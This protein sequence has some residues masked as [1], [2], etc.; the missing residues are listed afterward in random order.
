MTITWGADRYNM[1]KVQG[2]V[3]YEL[4]VKK[5]LTYV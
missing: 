2:I 1:G 4:Q 5:M 3:K